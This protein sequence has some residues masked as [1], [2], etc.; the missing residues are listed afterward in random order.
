MGPHLVE[1]S[2]SQDSPASSIVDSSQGEF[3][4]QVHSPD[5][6]ARSQTGVHPN[7]PSHQRFA[8]DH[9]VYHSPSSPVND[10]IQNPEQRHRN[11]PRA[12]FP[13]SSAGSSAGLRQRNPRAQLL[14]PVDPKT[15]KPYEG[16]LRVILP[17]AISSDVENMT[18]VGAGTG[19]FSPNVFYTASPY[20]GVDVAKPISTD[21]PF[22]A[23]R[24]PRSRSV[25]PSHPP[26]SLQPGFT[27]SKTP[28]LLVPHSS[29]PSPSPPRGIPNS[30]PEEQGNVIANIPRATAGSGGETPPL[31]GAGA[32][33][34][35]AFS[36]SS[37]ATCYV[38][39]KGH[40]KISGRDEEDPERSRSLVDHQIFPGGW[41]PTPVKEESELDGSMNDPEGGP[42]TPIQ[43]VSSRVSSPE[44]NRADST[45]RKSEAAVV[46]VLVHSP[47]PVPRLGRDMRKDSSSSG[48]GQGWVLVNFDGISPATP[49]EMSPTRETHGVSKLPEPITSPAGNGLNKDDVSRMATAII[50]PMNVGK[51]SKSK[52]KSTVVGVDESP[53]KRSFFGSS[54]KHSVSE[55]FGSS[56]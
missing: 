4:R 18:G 8:T 20:N 28:P 54:G 17:S 3:K 29:Y 46:D 12:A 7:S 38:S 23:H 5:H 33:R 45:L 42:D 40:D 49:I 37:R 55:F 2:S 52:S 34:D 27:R 30:V 35:S 32:F 44:L 10:D 13:T 50:D 14:T 36:S 25:T 51:K 48:T 39:I 53:P 41:Q 22:S 15:E 19:R 26:H 1:D 21:R 16:G 47:P 31:L 24:S 11:Y 6:L 56:Q 43:E 9:D